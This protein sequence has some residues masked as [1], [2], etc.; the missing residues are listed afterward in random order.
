MINQ[1]GYTGCD[2]CHS[3]NKMAETVNHLVIT[4][5]GAGQLPA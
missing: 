2:L 4:D 1:S 3:P 5:M